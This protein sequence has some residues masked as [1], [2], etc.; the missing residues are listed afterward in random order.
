MPSLI[1][2]L[3]SA[4]LFVTAAAPQSTPG[5]RPITMKGCVQATGNSTDF[6]LAVP[7]NVPRG[8]RGV[9]EGEPVPINAGVGPEARPDPQSTPP[10]HE[11]GASRLP[12]GRYSTPTEVNRSYKLLDLPASQL[13]ALVGKGVEVVGEIPVEGYPTGDE[14]VAGQPA[15]ALTSVL[16][17]PFRVKTIKKIADSCVA[18]IRSK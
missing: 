4:S 13:K 8:I 1:V 10:R 17:P 14:P 16:N 15:R 2:T 12:E 5:Y 3:A 11:P 6:L 7:D 9:G 18:L